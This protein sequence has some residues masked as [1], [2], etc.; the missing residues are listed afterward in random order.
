MGIWGFGFGF[1]SF[2][3]RKVSVSPRTLKVLRDT[4]T[5]E[6]AGSETTCLV[7]PSALPSVAQQQPG[8]H[9]LCC[10]VAVLAVLRANQAP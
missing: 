2:V 4:S 1:V 8:F 7:L 9:P 5:R 6:T 10:K 3:S